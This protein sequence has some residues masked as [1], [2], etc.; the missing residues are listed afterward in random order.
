MRGQSKTSAHLAVHP[1]D[2]NQ[3][4][5][6]SQGCMCDVSV[7]QMH[8]QRPG[9][10]IA[11]CGSCNA[12]RLRCYKET[13]ELGMHRQSET[14]AGNQRR[15]TRTRNASLPT[16]ANHTARGAR[17]QNPNQG[18]IHA[19]SEDTTLTSHHAPPLRQAQISQL[20]THRGRNRYQPSSHTG[21]ALV[22]WHSSCVCVCVC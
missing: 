1:N 8:V 15:H 10:G 13:Q 4:C 18:A 14:R 3:V 21:P 22:G 6:T 20:G 5:N 7:G 19:A 2:A 16:Q 12:L 17:K 9:W 11:V